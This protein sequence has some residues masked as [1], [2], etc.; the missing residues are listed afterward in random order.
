MNDKKRIIIPLILLIVIGTSLTSNSELANTR[1]VDI[2]QLV[3]FGI[4]FGVFIA[5]LKTV[6]WNKE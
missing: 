1:N 2:V 4:L 3:V 5:N 6:F